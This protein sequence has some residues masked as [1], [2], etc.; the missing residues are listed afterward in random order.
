M[1]YLGLYKSKQGK[2]T[3]DYKTYFFW[4]SGMVKMENRLF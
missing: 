4:F 3:D 1:E 2:W